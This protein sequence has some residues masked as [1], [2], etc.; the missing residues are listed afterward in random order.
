MKL[1]PTARN[2]VI[3]GVRIK[4]CTENRANAMAFF[5]QERIDMNIQYEGSAT[6]RSWRHQPHLVLLQAKADV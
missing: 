3:G 4:V 6:P 2:L 5:K 1:Y